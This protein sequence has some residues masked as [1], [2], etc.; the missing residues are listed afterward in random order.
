MGWTGDYPKLDENGKF[1]RKKFCDGLWRE[2][3]TVLKSSMVGTVYYAALAETKKWDNNEKKYKDVPK[4]EQRVFAE[5]VLTKMYRDGEFLYKSVPE[6]FGPC[7]DD[8]PAGILKLLSPTDDEYAL[9][10]RKRCEK[11]RKKRNEEKRKKI[12]K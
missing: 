7:E 5:V 3:V 2:T 10:W 8:C 1:D 12:Q 6:S 9:D 11:K 4:E